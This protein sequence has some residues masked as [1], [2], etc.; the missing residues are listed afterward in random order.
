MVWYKLVA[1]ECARFMAETSGRAAWGDLTRLAGGKEARAGA[2][3][4]R[5]Y[6]TIEDESGSRDGK[7]GQARGAETSTD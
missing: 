7:G 4:R 6:I 5:A 1:V 2:G 3:R